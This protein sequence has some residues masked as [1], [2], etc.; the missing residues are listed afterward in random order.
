MCKALGFCMKKSGIACYF[1]QTVPQEV[2][3]HKVVVGAWLN[4][5]VDSGSL[6]FW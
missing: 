2:P 3:D 4:A 5:V 6:Y 1:P